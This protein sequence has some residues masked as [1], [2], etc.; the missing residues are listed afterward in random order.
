MNIYHL[1]SS[2]GENKVVFGVNIKKVWRLFFALIY[3]ISLLGRPAIPVK[4]AA[5]WTAYNDSA[6][7]SGQT[8]PTNTTTILGITGTGALKNFDTGASTGVTATFTSSLSPTMQASSGTASNS[9]TDAYN[10]FNG[11]A[12]MIGVVNYGSLGWYID[13][14]LTGLNPA[15]TYTFAT[16]ATRNDSTY[17]A[18]N[19][20]YILSRDTAATNAS[21]S[22]VKVVNSHTIAFNTG[23]NLTQGYVA[24]WTGINPGSDGTIAIRARASTTSEIAGSV[25]Q[26][27][28]FSVFML[29][30]EITG[31]TITTS[32]S[33]SAFSSAPGVVSAEQSYT[34]SGSDLTDNI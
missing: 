30:E 28:G 34:V 12:N 17:T 11:K 13:L 32:G 23:T 19:T 24:R 20:T 33:L 9:G 3:V 21:T 7:V 5:A 6:W 10:T 16:S 27:Y 14:T 22:G 31:P 4:A 1:F 26:G 29:Q 18:R 25:Y 8:N 15:K 2:R